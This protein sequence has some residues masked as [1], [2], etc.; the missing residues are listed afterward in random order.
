LATHPAGNLYA[1]PA[2]YIA[3]SASWNFLPGK[4]PTLSI[5]AHARN[6]TAAATRT[7]LL[8]A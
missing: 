7:L 2:V 4:G 6:V 8:S 5:M 1:A 3:D